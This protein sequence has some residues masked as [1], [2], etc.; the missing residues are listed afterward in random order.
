MR[1][2]IAVHTPLGYDPPMQTLT[3]QD[4]CRRLALIEGQVSGLK[5]MVQD[6]RQCVDILTQVAAVRAAL[7]KLGAVVLT[8]HVE[9]CVSGAPANGGRAMNRDE[10]IHEVRLSLGRFLK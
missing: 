2:A 9:T 6:D 3:K 7:D 10:L 4:A 1:S 8:S 5:R